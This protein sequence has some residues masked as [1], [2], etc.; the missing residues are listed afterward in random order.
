[1]DRP[2][3]AFISLLHTG[4]AGFCL[5]GP[6]RAAVNLNIASV[7]SR[8]ECVILRENQALTSDLGYTLLVLPSTDFLCYLSINLVSIKAG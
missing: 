4:F 5:L 8:G 6:S 1:M 3:F 7:R 2:H